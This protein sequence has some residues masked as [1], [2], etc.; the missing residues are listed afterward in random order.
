MCFSTNSFANQAEDKYTQQGN[1]NS[2][3]CYDRKP[4]RIHW[5]LENKTGCIPE[6]WFRCTIQVGYVK[7]DNHTQFLKFPQSLTLPVRG[8]E[9]EASN[10]ITNNKEH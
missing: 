7:R 10:D 1:S 8:L 9:L 3:G 4:M 2:N 5:F 6:I